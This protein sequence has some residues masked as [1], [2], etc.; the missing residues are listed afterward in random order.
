VL[1]GDLAHH[2][3][4]RANL[5]VAIQDGKDPGV[6]LHLVADQVGQRMTDRAVQLADHD[7]RL[8]AEMVLGSL[9]QRLARTQDDPFAH[10]VTSVSAAA[11]SRSS[12]P[13][14]DGSRISTGAG[15]AIARRS[16]GPPGPPKPRWKPHRMP[17]HL[18]W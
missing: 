5:D 1:D 7:L 17:A 10:R 6:P 4:G 8:G 16:P 13:R 15:E 18:P 2:H 9:H 14:I 11:I 12:S 3:R